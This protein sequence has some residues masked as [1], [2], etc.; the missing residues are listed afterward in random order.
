RARTRHSRSAQDSSTKPKGF[1]N[2]ASPRMRA[3]SSRVV[4]TA[5]P[6]TAGD[7]VLGQFL[8]GIGEDPVSR[9][10]LDQIAEMEIPGALRYAR[11]L[12]HVVGHDHDR[13]VGAQF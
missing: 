10:H 8:L 2:A 9:P 4:C 6:E 1:R 12:L 13:I 7:V 11:R 3:S 5:S